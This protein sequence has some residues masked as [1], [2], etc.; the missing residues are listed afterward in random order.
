[1]SEI[2]IKEQTLD[3]GLIL[4]EFNRILI[5][6]NAASKQVCEEML[7]MITHIVISTGM[8]VVN[9]IKSKRKRDKEA[10]RVMGI[11]GCSDF[12]ELKKFDLALY[13]KLEIFISKLFFMFLQER[14]GEID[15][16]KAMGDIRAMREKS[17]PESMPVI[18]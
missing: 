5:E 14:Y 17:N 16:K 4:N 7:I 18:H 10:K 9:G 1:M 15:V 11:V 6:G 3:V 8:D 13:I 2:E 12:Q